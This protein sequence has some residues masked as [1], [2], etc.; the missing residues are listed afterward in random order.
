MFFTGSSVGSTITFGVSR[1]R[2]RIPLR[3]FLVKEM[4]ARSSYYKH[5]SLGPQD[6]DRSLGWHVR[7]NTET[8][9]PIRPKD[10][11]V[12]KGGECCQAYPGLG[13]RSIFSPGSSVGSTIT[14]PYN[15]GMEHVGFHIPDIAPSS[16]RREVFGESHEGWTASYQE[17]LVRR[18]FLRM[19]GS[20]DGIDRVF[21][22]AGVVYLLATLRGSS[23]VDLFGRPCEIL[24]PK[25][26]R[27]S[28]ARFLLL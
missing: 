12:P 4:R 21:Y 3:R 15:A 16:K 26:M 10:P 17:P 1:T 11:A 2:V 9:Q 19:G 7:P 5:V 28:S 23:S 20:V 6:L 25:R 8:R 13:S 27:S 18:S 14:H 24:L 22:R